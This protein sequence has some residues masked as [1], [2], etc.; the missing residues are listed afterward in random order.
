MKWGP[1]MN[2]G[3]GHVFAREDGEK[4]P[5]DGPSECTKCA[6]DLERKSKLENF[7][8]REAAFKEAIDEL[9]KTRSLFQ[10]MYETAK[11]QV[12]HREAALREHNN[13]MNVLSTLSHRFEVL[14]GFRPDLSLIQ[15]AK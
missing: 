12:K 3:H 1:P 2:W 8:E 14:A 6:R 9:E 5:C 4:W 15:E 10:L 13:L 11:I 7:P